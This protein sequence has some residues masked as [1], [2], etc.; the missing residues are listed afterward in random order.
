MFVY[1]L[2][3]GRPH[4]DN[5]KLLK[6]PQKK[7]K[8]LRQEHEEIAAEGEAGHGEARGAH[9]EVGQSEGEAEQ[10]RT[11]A[12]RQEHG[13]AEGRRRKSGDGGRDLL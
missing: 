3:S 2:W 1:Q 8:K 7:R 5:P 13:E 4:V 10:A 11:G 12:D 6:D 9:R